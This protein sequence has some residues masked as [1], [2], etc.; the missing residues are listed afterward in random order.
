VTTYFVGAD[1]RSADLAGASLEG[2]RWSDG[3]RRPRTLW[4]AE[5][6]KAVWASS[7]EV[8][9]EPGIFEIRGRLELFDRDPVEV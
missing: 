3:T 6:E 2:V 9:G 8:K 1:L 4:P 5:H 7:V